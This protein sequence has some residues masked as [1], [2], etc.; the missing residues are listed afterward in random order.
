MTLAKVTTGKQQ[1]PHRILLYGTEGIGKSTFGANAPKPIFV[2]VEEGSHHLDVARFP[3]PETWKDILDAVRAVTVDAHDYQTLVIDTVDAAEPL[4]W[5]HMIDRDQVKDKNGKPTLR[6]IESYPWGK[7]FQKAL[8]DWR[9]LLKVLETLQSTRGMHVILLAHS[10]VR[11]FKNPEGEGYDRYELKVHTK[12]GGLLKEW[13]DCVLFA[14]LEVFEKKAPGD[15]KRVRGLD[16]GARLL[17]VERRAAYDAKN[18]FGLT[19][20]VPLSW[21]DFDEATKREVDVASLTAEVLRKAKELG[22]ELEPK[23]VETVTKAAGNVASLIT[24]NN[25]INMRLAEKAAQEEEG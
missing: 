25:R 24:I 4:L 12:A 1:Q 2:G 19:E 9:A 13:A 3:K 20:S 11:H 10:Q 16:S 5:R 21:A 6:D 7:G 23:V 15:S 22:P 17:R 8:E 14:Q 18:R